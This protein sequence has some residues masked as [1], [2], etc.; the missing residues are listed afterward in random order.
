MS[1]YK[2][3]ALFLSSIALISYELYVMRIFSIGG[4]SAFGSLVISTALLGVGLSGILITL[5]SKMVEKYSDTILSLSAITL[6]LLMTLAV[7]LS[8]LIPFNPVY[9][10]ADA[11][12][13]FYIGLY[14]LIYGIPFFVGAFFIGVMFFTFRSQIQKL[15]FWNMI[16]SGV[17]GFFIIIFMF[18]LPPEFLIIPILVIT[19]LASILISITENKNGENNNIKNKKNVT[20]EI[21]VKRFLL[22]CVCSILSF[23]F[24]FNWGGIHVSDTKS[25]SYVRKYPDAKLVHHSF[26][27]GGEYHVYYSKYFHFAPG[28]SDNAALHIPVMPS[29]PYWGMF[30]DGEGPIGIMGYLREGEKKYMDYLPM[31]APYTM[32][33]QPKV[34]LINL[35]GGVNT[36]IARYKEASQIDILEPSAEM[37]S[38]L[39]YDK[40]ITRFNGGLLA[41]KNINV[42]QNE[43]RTWCKSHKNSYDLIEISL[44]DS[45]GLNDSGGY[46]IHED[47]KWTVEAFKEYFGA[48]KRD[49]ILSLTVWDKLTPPRNVLKLVNTIREA[50]KEANILGIENNIYSFGLFMSTTTILV[51]KSRWDFKQID[52]LNDFVKTRTF[53]TFYS[54]YDDIQGANSSILSMLNSYKRQFARRSGGETISSKEFYKAA[55]P[56]LI[57]GNKK[58]IEDN[59]IF[60]IREIRDSRPYYSGF[61][62]PNLFS[63]YMKNLKSLSEEWGYLLLLAM[64]AQACFFGIIVIVV[65]LVIGRQTVFSALDGKPGI[66]KAASVILYYSSLG[67]AYMLIEIFLIQRLALYLANPIYS[68]S[69]VITVMLI[70]SAVGNIVSV[71]FK[72]NRIYLVAISTLLI[73]LILIFYIF[74]LGGLLSA[75]SSW[76]LALH[77]IIAILLIAPISFFMGIPYPNGL[78]S[79]Q[80]SSPHLLPWAWGLNGGLSVAGSAL[81][82]I[83]SVN[84]GFSTLLWI[85]IVLYLAVGILFKSANNRT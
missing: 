72:E 47:Y 26:T 79:L 30:V 56:L 19:I 34:L 80:K 55:L 16:G 74:A 24:V 76:P 63:T 44:V 59:Y 70:S 66:I 83:I 4:W 13:F 68:T 69:I 36:Q 81:S 52:I 35:S 10:S 46:A 39:K 2:I 49:G 53:E 73:V 84:S 5:C 41:E 18:F 1:K 22:I 23:A 38:L 57:S 8:Q 54:P 50:M 62:K 60:D 31:S 15:Y 37:I 6:P 25:I 45:I 3:S 27:P 71:R 85:T 42:I 11:R 67:L 17:G 65:P 61:L 32:L 64:F 14:Y 33:K 78:D 75:T 12:Q 21:S 20:S 43:G 51:K 48:L 40:N 28:L 7:I 58:I 82:R 9:L 77:I 29:Q